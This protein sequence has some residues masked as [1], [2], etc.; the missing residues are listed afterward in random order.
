MFFLKSS[1]L[2]IAF[3]LGS[4]WASVDEHVPQVLIV[5]ELTPLTPVIFKAPASHVEAK[6]NPLAELLKFRSIEARQSY[7]SSGYGECTAYPGKCCQIGGA[8]C[9]S[10][11]TRILQ[12][13]YIDLTHVSTECCDPGYFCYGTHAYYYQSRVFISQ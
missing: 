9:S 5:P 3:F 11:S 2:F 6:S 10:K 8:C 4:A 13:V 12:F 1:V 7:C